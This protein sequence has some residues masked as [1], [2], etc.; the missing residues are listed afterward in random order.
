VNRQANSFS[1]GIM[2][3]T[4]TLVS[5]AF[6]WLTLV[7]FTMPFVV[8]YVLLCIGWLL[9]LVVAW[10]SYGSRLAR[11]SGAF[12][13]LIKVIALATYSSA[14]ASYWQDTG[15]PEFSEGFILTIFAPLIVVNCVYMLR[16]WT[17]SW[18]DREIF[19][20]HEYFN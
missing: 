4:M 3:R 18:H 9:A 5:L 7:R 1:L 10:R 19:G 14:L 8:F 15:P 12:W 16:Q 6:G 20:D 13:F 17:W 2:F 11:L